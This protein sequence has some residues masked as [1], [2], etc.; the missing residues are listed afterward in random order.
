MM[1]EC[2][3]LLIYDIFMLY[4]HLVNA[5]MER[6]MSLRRTAAITAIFTAGALT[7]CNKEPSPLVEQSYESCMARYKGKSADEQEKAQET[8]MFEMIRTINDL[9][10]PAF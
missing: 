10:G 6:I 7:G 1:D 4:I 9:E 2:K 3:F 5:F 8:C